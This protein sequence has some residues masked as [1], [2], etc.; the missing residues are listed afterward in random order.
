MGFMSVA[1]W[2]LLPIFGGLSV[3][4]TVLFFVLIANVAL[5]RFGIAKFIVHVAGLALILALT[6]DAIFSKGHEIFFYSYA[7]GVLLGYLF[8]ALLY[9]LFRSWA[10]EAESD[11]GAPGRQAPDVSD[12]SNGVPEER[13]GLSA[14]SRLVDASN[15]VSGSSGHV[16]NGKD[17]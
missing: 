2:L 4:S 8:Y 16:K 3:A 7:F 10:G 13:K 14:D 11:G 5:R 6:P 9:R 15:E 1:P 12:P 17:K